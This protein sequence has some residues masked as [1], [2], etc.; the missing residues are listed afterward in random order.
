MIETIPPTISQDPDAAGRSARPEAS[1]KAP[2]TRRLADSSNVRN[3]DA[4]SGLNKARM[5]ARA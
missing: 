3:D 5:P 4:S 2:T 1:R